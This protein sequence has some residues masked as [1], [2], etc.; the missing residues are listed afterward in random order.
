M[1]E[2]SSA[3]KLLL[4]VSMLSGI[5]PGIL[6]KILG[7][8][9]LAELQLQNLPDLAAQIAQVLQVPQLA[10]ALRDTKNWA[11]AQELA[12][13]Q[14]RLAKQHGARI[15][16]PLDADYPALLTPTRDA[17]PILYVKGA[18]AKHPERSVA[19]IGTREP[20]I[21]GDQTATQITQ[22]FAGKGWSIVSGL[23]RGCDA[24]AHRAA[25][26]AG[27]HTVAV[28]AH[29]L[30]MIAPAQNKQLAADIIASGGAL[31]SQYPF[32]QDVERKQYVERDHTQAG[33][34][35]GVVMIQSSLDGGSLHASRASLS[36]GRWLAVPYPNEKDVSRREDSIQ[37]NLLLATGTDS[38]R[39]S[40]LRCQ[41][42]SLKNLMVLKGTADYVGML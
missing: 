23:A 32:G 6:K 25:I 9:G 21:N 26:K 2:I 38:E 36:Y 31:V 34:S 42:N 20:T 19:I 11:A 17:P 37:A 28:L 22:F 15:L 12:E 33:M 18:L 4:S 7:L 39:T 16:S 8:P 5:N 24:I 1:S 40:L 27:A 14:C 3:T 30:H 10:S 41:A 29:G 13:A 35:Q